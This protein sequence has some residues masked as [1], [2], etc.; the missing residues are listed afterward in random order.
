MDWV[1]LI[2]VG[3]L[4]GWLA[5]MI[6]KTPMGLIVDVL[7]GII[8]S[9][10]GR[11]IFSDILGIGGAAAAGTFSVMGL[12]WGVIG[13]VVLLAILRGIGAMSPAHR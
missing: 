5:G 3:A 2:L 10:L 1:V 13:A 11:W 6:M 9:I 7:V 4:I 8:G 12:V